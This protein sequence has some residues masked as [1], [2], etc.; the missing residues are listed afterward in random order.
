MNYLFEINDYSK[1]NGLQSNRLAL[2]CFLWG[3]GV[4]DIEEISYNF[5][6]DLKSAIAEYIDN[7]I[8]A[9][10][11][12]DSNFRK[13]IIERY[14]ST[15]IFLEDYF[16][17]KLDIYINADDA[18]RKK[19]KAVTKPQDAITKLSEL[20]TLR[21]NKPEPS[22]NSIDD[23]IRV[24]KR[25]RFLVR[26]PY[27]RKEV[28]NPSK[29]SA[30]IESIMLGITLPA[31]FIY[32]RKNGINE[33][34]DGQQRI[35]TLLGFIGS[36]Y[37]NE[38]EETA[39]SKNHKFKLRNLR[40]LNE[41]EG[42]TYDKL[43]DEIKDKIL[44]FQLYI[45]EIEEKQNL[46]FDPI[47]LF[48][49]LNDKPFPIRENSFEMWNSWV[50][51]DVIKKI[52]GLTE[53]YKPWFYVKQIKGLNDRDRMENEELITSISFLECLKELNDRRKS[54]DI[55]Q[56]TERINARISNK[57]IIS[58]LLQ[59][60]SDQENN[61][62]E[63]FLKS[64]RNTESFIRKLSIILLDQDKTSKEELNKY[65]QNELNDIFRANR[66]RRSFR[67]TLQDFYILW[68]II[69]DI[70]LEMIK[71]NRIQM[72]NEIKEIYK[73]IKAIPEPDQE[74]SKG[75]KNFFDM[76]ESFK[77]IY[78]IEDR[79][80]TLS[81]EQKLDLLQKQGNASYISGAKIFIGDEIEIDHKIPISKG[82]KDSIDNLR[83]VHKDENRKKGAKI[84][85]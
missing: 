45:V 22:R 18:Q 12:E 79:T 84:L 41:Y 14:L 57:K 20:E 74:N 38:K 21:L 50:D 65:L 63:T 54:L 62:K 16:K 64:I 52:K 7:N 40:I 47:D 35:L 66:Q 83:I 1:K 8:S 36:E 68:Y 75:A 29:A 46:N 67:R 80:I 42:A 70:N 61:I 77:K 10:K 58:N 30:I 37:I 81:T 82:G 4:L 43:S 73:Y 2:E 49:R 39:Y 17:I 6:D 23:I 60:V 13:E 56:K 31:L 69:N 71:H 55:Y 25:R 78:S 53:K 26:P 3:F 76:C 72:K 15:A 48:I 32:K 85:K 24:M 5:N 51:I 34:I 9:Y 11:E 33:V 59:Q 27:Q 28:I 44:D 19:I